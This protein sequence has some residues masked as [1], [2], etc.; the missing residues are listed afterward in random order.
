MTTEN[1][2]HDLLR[3]ESSKLTAYPD[4]LTG[5]HPWTIGV[6]HTGLDVHEGLVW[7]DDQVMAA[8][9]HDIA[10]A[11]HGLEE[12]SIAPW[13]GSLSDLRQDCLV[14]MAFNLG[15]HGLLGFNT[16]LGLL[17]AGDYKGAAEDLRGTRWHRQVGDRA[18]RI[19]N[20]I[21]TGVHQS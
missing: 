4:P 12:S 17:K 9:A 8:L 2:P 11:V 13:W 1:L 15:V 10:V 3:D 16:F 21:E 14:N 5:G 6:G 19:A 7:S 18:K 20:Q